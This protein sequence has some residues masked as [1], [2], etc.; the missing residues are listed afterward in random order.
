MGIFIITTDCIDKGG[1]T[2][3]FITATLVP[4]RKTCEEINGIY[5]ASYNLVFNVKK[6]PI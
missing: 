4:C 2:S 6:M 3:T 5:V 1:S